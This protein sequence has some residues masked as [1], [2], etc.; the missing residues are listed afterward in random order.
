MPNPLIR[1]SAIAGALTLA[2][3]AVPAHA[4]PGRFV[5]EPTEDG[6]VRMD[7][8]TGEMSICAAEDAQIVCTP[9]ADERAA[10]QEKLE[11]L[12]ARIALLER[13]L[14][15]SAGSAIAREGLP[16]DEEFERGLD[17]M[18]DFM[19]RFMGLLDEFQPPPDRT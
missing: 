6:Y 8:Q 7:T 17:R 16:S 18:E 4:E 12:E 3:I 1:R 9:I 13:R 14:N 15:M 10:F 11:E 5:M 2:V 19:R